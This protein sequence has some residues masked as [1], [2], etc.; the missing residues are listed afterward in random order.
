MDKVTDWLSG[1]ARLPPMLVTIPIVSPE[2]W[3]WYWN[4]ARLAGGTAAGTAGSGGGRKLDGGGNWLW[5]ISL[6][7]A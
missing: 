7:E 2:N 4:S 1:S 6:L 5:L 3:E